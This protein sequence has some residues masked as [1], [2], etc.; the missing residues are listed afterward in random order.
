MYFDMSYRFYTKPSELWT[1]LNWDKD[2][3]NPIPTQDPNKHGE[4][5][6]DDLFGE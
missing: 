2:N 6:E 1:R 3:K 5:I 4:E